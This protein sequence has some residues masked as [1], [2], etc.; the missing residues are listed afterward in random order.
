[1]NTLGAALG[2]LLYRLAATATWSR[3]PADVR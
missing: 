1:M 3:P 2:Y